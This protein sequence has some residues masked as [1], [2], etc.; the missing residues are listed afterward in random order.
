[1]TPLL[2]NIKILDL[3]HR[4]PGPYA[5]MILSKLGAEVI[6]LEDMTFQ[7]PFKSGL[8]HQFDPSFESWYQELNQTKKIITLDFNQASDIEKIH[9]LVSQVDGIIMGLPTKI[10]MALNL[11]SE[12]IKGLKKPLAMVDMKASKD[13]MPAMHDLNAMAEI[14]ILKLYLQDFKAQKIV[15]PPFLPFLGA[16]FGHNVATQ[17]ISAILKS[18]L[19]NSSVSVSAYMFDDCQELYQPFY[20]KD[21]QESGR[22]RFLHNGAYPCYCI[23]QL[24]DGH[25]AAL[26]A[27]EEK[28][29]EILVKNLNLPLPKEARFDTKLESFEA[30][31]DVF[32]TLSSKELAEFIKMHDACLSLIKI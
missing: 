1:M 6:K 17:L 16:S 15:P 30:V 5:G 26:A 3:S 12:Q 25:Y 22:T 27:V 8:F 13:K 4:L 31:A 14:G 32:L 28:F 7:D 18:K 9:Q 23:Y 20:S 11:S 29:W 24:K 10:Q 21:L 2:S 19:E